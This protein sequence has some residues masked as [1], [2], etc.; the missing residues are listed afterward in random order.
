MAVPATAQ[1]A[2]YAQAT[3][4]SLGFR[5]TPHMFGSTFGI[6]KTWPAGP[7]AVGADFRGVMVKRGGTDGSNNDQKLDEGQFGVRAAASPG[8]LPFSLQ[9]Y[10]EALVGMGYWRGGTGVLRQDKTHGLMQ[11]VVGA[12]LPIFRNVEWRIAEF[13]Y[14]RV[15]AQPGFLNPMS[16]STGFVIRLPQA[17]A[18]Q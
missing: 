2:I 1:V 8:I 9:P 11:L 15:G 12:D 6:Y 17:K 10:A 7:V 3:G 14:A 18:R 5:E 16:I 4:A 13:S